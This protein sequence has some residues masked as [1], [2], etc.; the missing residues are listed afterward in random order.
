MTDMESST[1]Q[2]DAM[3][4]DL[5]A[6]ESLQT[7]NAISKMSEDEIRTNLD[8]TVNAQYL[9]ERRVAD[10]ASIVLNRLSKTSA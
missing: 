1:G 5:V 3:A 2:T 9:R 7:N 8:S 4:L 6:T 10:N